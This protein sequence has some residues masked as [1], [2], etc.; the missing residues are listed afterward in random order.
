MNSPVIFP[1]LRG[2]GDCRFHDFRGNSRA[3]GHMRLDAY[4]SLIRI[5]KFSRKSY[6]KTR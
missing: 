6:F 3:I 5:D 2:K 4:D 1:L